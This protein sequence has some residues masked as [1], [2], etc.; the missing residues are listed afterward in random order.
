MV[1]LTAR[2]GQKA[3]WTVRDWETYPTVL[4]GDI[5][6]NDVTDARGVV[7]DTA[8]IVGRNTGNV[9]T[10]SNAN[11]DTIFDGFFVTAGSRNAGGG[12]CLLTVPLPFCR[13]SSLAR[14]MADGAVGVCTLIAA[15]HL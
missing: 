7:T 2:P 4:S 5:D 9:V 14:T 6:G 12:V 1:V 8:N 13:I 15:H 10:I 3:I 11:A